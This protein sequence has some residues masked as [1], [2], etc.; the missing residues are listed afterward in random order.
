MHKHA[1][2]FMSKLSRNALSQFAATLLALAQTDLHH[3]W[4]D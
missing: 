1:L 3:H 4:A 2:Q